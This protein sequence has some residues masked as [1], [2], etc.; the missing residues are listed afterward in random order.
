MNVFGYANLKWVYFG[1]DYSRQF[2]SML[3]A[4]FICNK[5]W[6]RNE[7]RNLE[8]SVHF[9]EEA[10]FDKS[11]S[12]D[13]YKHAPFL[14]PL[15]ASPFALCSLSCPVI[16]HILLLNE[17]V[18]GNSTSWIFYHS[19]FP[20]AFL[21]F[22]QVLPSLTPESVLWISILISASFFFGSIQASVTCFSSGLGKVME[23]NLLLPVLSVSV[24]YKWQNVLS[25]LSLLLSFL[26]WLCNA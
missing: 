18:H 19:L 21:F 13:A 2:D 4:R 1:Q 6:K 8:V 11:Q 10:S 16:F 5:C 3:N 24:L 12:S 9:V 15:K 17:P 23:P 7:N 25:H 26:R 20:P 22:I 14:L